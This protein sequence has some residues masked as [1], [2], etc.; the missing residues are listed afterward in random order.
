MKCFDI[1][2]F[3][4]IFWFL[5]IEGACI[6]DLFLLK[7]LLIVRLKTKQSFFVIRCSF[8]TVLGET[9]LLFQYGAPFSLIFEGVNE[10]G[11]LF[12]EGIVFGSH[13]SAHALILPPSI[14]QK[15]CETGKKVSSKTM[16]L[17][18]INFVPAFLPDLSMVSF[19]SS[20]GNQEK[21]HQE[22]L[23]KTADLTRYSLQNR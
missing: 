13:F 4:A 20:N 9:Q 16:E 17:A 22:P 2:E 14:F 23:Y 21:N 7:M 19:S 10:E 5:G 1:L 15:S 12:I 6:N 11:K 3:N 8:T 18:I